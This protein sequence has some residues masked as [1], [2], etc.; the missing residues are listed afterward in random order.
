MHLARQLS[1]FSPPVGLE[2]LTG[3]TGLARLEG[4]G[5]RDL[6]GFSFEPTGSFG[7]TGIATSTPCTKIGRGS[8][9]G[10]NSEEEVEGETEEF[11]VEAE[12]FKLEEVE[13]FIVKR[14]SIFYI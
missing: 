14:C 10:G 7:P 5:D 4:L 1:S 13:E 8:G 6:I 3:L 2:G 11:E 12:E 9:S